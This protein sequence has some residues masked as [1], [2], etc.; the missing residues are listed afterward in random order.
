MLTSVGLLHGI[1]AVGILSSDVEP[2]LPA[3]PV[4]R[5]GMYSHTGIPGCDALHGLF[6][7][8]IT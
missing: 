3:L 7:A 4:L 5:G 2:T 1:Q 8:T 6:F